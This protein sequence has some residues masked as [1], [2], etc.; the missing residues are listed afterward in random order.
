MRMTH[1][2]G[3]ST[4]SFLDGYGTVD[5]IAARIISLGHTAS[6]VTDHGNIFAHVPMQKAYKKAGLKAIFG[7]EFYVV[8]NMTDR[9][10]YN[11]SLGADGFP[12]ATIVAV[13]QK[14]YDNLLKLV[15]IASSEG[16]YYKPRIDWKTIAKYQDGIA[17]L[18]GCVG[19]YPSRLLLGEK[20]IEGAHQFVE[21][22]M[23]QIERYFV[24]IVPEPGLGISHST[25][26]Q[27]IQIA[28]DLRCPLV[29]T[30]DAHFPCPADHWAQDTLLMVGL[31]KKV[32]DV[33][34]LKLPDY[35][36]YCT[37]EEL[38]Q[39]GMECTG[40]LYKDELIA[41]MAISADIA[42]ACEVEIPMAKSVAF[43][44]AVGK[45]PSVV[46]RQWVEEGFADRKAM[47][48]VPPAREQEYRDR[49][50]REFKTIAGK[51]FADYLLTLTFI[52]RWAK[53]Q[54]SLVMN[55]GSAGGCL[56]LWVLSCG[57]TDSIAHELSFERFYDDTRTD[58]PDVDV[59][60]ETEFREN[61]IDFI[62]DAFGSEN[63]SQVAALT[64]LRAKNAVADIASVYGI[65]RSEYDALSA[66]LDS[67][68][69][70][71]DAQIEAVE[72]EGA[73][74][75]L[76]SYPILRRAAELIGQCRNQS[77]NAAGFVISA[78]PL[79]NVVATIKTPGKHAFSSVDKHGAGDIGLLKFDLLGVAAFDVIGKAM[80]KIYGGE[81]NCTHRLYTLPLDDPA[82]YDTAKS[83]KIAGVFQLDGAAIRVA[84]EIGLD[85]FEELYA[86]SALC[87][88]GA[89]D[90]VP[91]YKNNKYDKVAFDAYLSSIHPIA[92]GIVRD[93]YGVLLYQE[94]VMRICKELAGMPWPQVNKLRKRISAAS[95]NG[96]ALG[97]EYGDDFTNGCLAN[98]VSPKET[99]DWWEAIKKHG[100]YSFNKSH[101][102]TYGIVG[103]WMLWLKTYHPSAYYEAYLNVEGASSSRNELLMKRLVAEY[104]EGGG[105]V[106][107]IDPMLSKQGFTSP[108]EGL[109]VGGWQNLRGVG[110]KVAE[111]IV[112]AGPYENWKEV[113]KAAD[114]GR[115][116]MHLYY[117]VFETGITKD[118]D[119][120]PQ[121]TIQLA[122]WAPVEATDKCDAETREEYKLA[123]PGHMPDRSVSGDITVGGYVTARHIKGRTGSFKGETILW[124]LEDE[125]GIITL[126]VPSKHITTL[127]QRVKKEMKIGDYI[128]AQGWWAG[129]V[130]FMKDFVR[131]SRR[132]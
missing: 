18:S 93:T 4:Y 88:P 61:V 130:L 20:G 73:L 112:A 36:Y 119:F 33:R 116:P 8:D 98:G 68:D 57:E 101:C 122:S 104:R 89:M 121:A 26:P 30:S 19:G 74:Q 72:D 120:S 42:D 7:C 52:C 15:T 107:I 100:V 129:D 9:T 109:I 35:Q 66:K 75:V 23:Q 124:G 82:V 70:G 44:G 59:D 32:T 111:E 17:V 65:P 102:V 127:G 14:G 58:P 113:K 48:L 29:M 76:A 105:A 106:C 84:Q 41:A 90:H 86:C 34:T 94:Q 25:T 43:P 67:K 46:L 118:R 79:N 31:N 60:F 22:R 27:L 125:T 2:H 123:R 56:L 3:H 81:T 6:A 126:R 21:E 63:C 110:D 103:Y 117:K 83:G 51:G 95:F 92:A 24:E 64:L 96:H 97:R 115:F 49:I 16:Y 11:P 91:L 54:D 38:L 40:G 87:R 85:T 12:H 13:T 5:Q 50:E 1:I 37:A 53:E 71:F 114:E 45:D 55:R 69:D 132:E 128:A 62:F 80:R 77:I 99:H 39:R 28:A 108:L 78:E 47:G 10:K 131:I